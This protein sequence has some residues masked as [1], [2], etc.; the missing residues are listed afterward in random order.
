MMTADSRRPTDDRQILR[1]AQDDKR[2][3]QDDGEG[4]EFVATLTIDQ[5]P[6]TM[7]LVRVEG[8]HVGCFKGRDFSLKVRVLDGVTLRA[9]LERA[10]R[11]LE[12]AEL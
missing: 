1:S 6:V 2:Y 8:G 11:F 5:A 12:I 4:C 7:E 3:A 10:R 9:A